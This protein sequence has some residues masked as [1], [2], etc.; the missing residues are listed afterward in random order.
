M[1]FLAALG[2]SRSG[3][4]AAEMA[5]I[6]PLLLAI[7]FGSVELGN[8]FYNEHKLLKAVRDGAR[9][10]ARQQFSNYA[11]CTGSVPASGTPGTVYE[12]TKLIVRK[13]KLSTTA[14]DLLPNWA[15]ATASCTGNPA[16]G[17]FE[18]TMSCTPDLDDVTTGNTLALGGIYTNST[19]APTVVVNSRLPYYSVLG[20]TLG[21]NS[22]GIYLNARQSAAV[23]GL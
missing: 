8:Y 14:P 12:N 9:Y 23:A 2:A 1:N 7:L 21:F 19:G 22:I 15:G 10:A 20:R 13:G 11:A 17:C 6:A 3:A 5:M 18:V 16:A 4:A